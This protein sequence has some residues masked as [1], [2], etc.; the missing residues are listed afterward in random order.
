VRDPAR[1]S[2]LV[3]GQAEILRGL[4]WT[5]WTLMNEIIVV[6]PFH[7][8]LG[9]ANLENLLAM[10]TGRQIVLCKRL[11]SRLRYQECRG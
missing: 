10:L 2:R 6:L 7:P 8:F 11:Y 1:P 9:V 4:G 3:L 5:F